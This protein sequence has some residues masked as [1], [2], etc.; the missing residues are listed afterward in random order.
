MEQKPASILIVDDDASV[1]TMLHLYLNTKGY[2]VGT[3]GNG[4]EAIEHLK[5]NRYD[6]IITDLA[7]PEMNG[8]QLIDAVKTSYREHKIIAISASLGNRMVL[9]Q[10]GVLEALEKPFDF[11]QLL[12][13]I[14]K[15][16]QEKRKAKRFFSEAGLKLTCILRG[17][18]SQDELRCGLRDISIDGAMLE[19]EREVSCGAVDL[20]FCVGSTAGMVVR[21]P[22]RVVRKHQ[23]A[24]GCWM[25][26]VYFDDQRDL[27][28]LEQLMPYLTIEKGHARN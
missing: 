1:T 24:N 23:E 11:D 22:G 28:L 10:K 7:M 8:Y 19:L 12:E 16:H 3:A 17:R 21:V 4:K 18:H 9:L 13:E 20:D 15:L 26:G 27:R 5:K 6:I 14:N 2:Q 25:T